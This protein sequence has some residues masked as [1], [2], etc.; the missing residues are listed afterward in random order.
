MYGYE[1]DSFI[2]VNEHHSG[3]K[4]NEWVKWSIRSSNFIK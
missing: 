2:R 1:G 3:Y 4:W